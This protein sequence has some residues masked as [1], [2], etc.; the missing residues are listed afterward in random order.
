MNKSM[1]ENLNIL[2]FKILS[3]SW[4]DLSSLENYSVVVEWIH[5]PMDMFFNLPLLF[6]FYSYTRGGRMIWWWHVVSLGPPKKGDSEQP[7]MW[8]FL[9]PCWF[10]FIS[11]GSSKVIVCHAVTC[12]ISHALCWSLG[13]AE[14]LLS[15]WPC[16]KVTVYRWKWQCFFD[17]LLITSSCD[18]KV[19][20]AGSLLKMQKY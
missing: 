10:F 15:L 17:I 8:V 19:H 20:R 3:D 4:N 13:Y 9:G 18:I 11:C 7:L 1:K 12:H 16:S 14:Q 6:L 5:P 2:H